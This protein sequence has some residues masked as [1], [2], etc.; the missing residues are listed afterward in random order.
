MS[1]VHIII[2]GASS[3]GKS[4]LVDECL[5]KFHQDKKLQYKKFKRV[6]EVARNVLNRLKMTGKDLENYIKKKNI[7]AFSD[8]QQKIIQEQV[9]CF[10]REKRNHFLS[11]RSGF[12]ALAYIHFYFNN[13]Q[14]TNSVFES[15]LFQQLIDQCRNGLIFI[16]QP[17][18]DLQAQ[19]DN[20]RIVPSYQDQINYTDCLRYW[21]DKAYLPYFVIA[22]LDLAKR[23][24]FIH[25]HINGHFHWLPPE[26]P[27]PLNIPFHLNKPKHHGNNQ[28]SIASNSN[29]SYMRYIEI[30]DKQNVKISYKKYDTN[31]IV[32]KYDP[33]CL[34]NKFGSILFDQKLDNTFLENIL[35]NGIYI[36]NQ[37]YNFIGYS[38]SQLRGRSCYLYAGPINEI[39]QMIDDNGDFDKIKNISK[40]AARIGLLFSSCTPTIHI[41]SEQVIQI[42]DVERNGHTFT[43]G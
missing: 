43:D 32:E 24:E 33:S 13:E 42:D 10:D 2:S 38:N 37:Q 19:N 41:Q 11:D 39:Q 8:V 22:D 17:Q 5:R 40:R 35:S 26:F 23:V 36:N 29:Q 15:E 1:P 16:I 25:Q 30:S 12:D 3:V 27:L 31:R 34:N 20:M 18:Q 6:Q 28:I 9:L 4:T 21:Y 14:K 7:N